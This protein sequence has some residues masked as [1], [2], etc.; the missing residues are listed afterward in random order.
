MT[1]SR[2]QALALAARLARG[3]NAQEA[4]RLVKTHV[5]PGRVVAAIEVKRPPKGAT[6]D[7]RRR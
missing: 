5:P 7:N 6:S 3:G 1:L 4:R 2:A